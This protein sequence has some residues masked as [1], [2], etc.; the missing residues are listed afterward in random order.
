M[1][2][3]NTDKNDSLVDIY[4]ELDDKRHLNLEQI[5]FMFKIYIEAYLSCRNTFGKD[6]NLT[7]YC[8]SEFKKFYKIIK[9]ENSLFKFMMKNLHK[10]DLEAASRVIDTLDELNEKTV[11]YFV[12]IFDS[13]QTCAEMD[14][15]SRFFFTRK[16]FK[17]LNDTDYYKKMVVGL[18][19]NEEYIR[20]YLNYGEDFWNYVDQYRKS[21]KT[22]PEVASKMAFAVPIFD[23]DN[24]VVS[25]RLFV[26]EVVDLETAIIS[27]NTY[28]KAYNI[29][30]CF[31]RKIDI[32]LEKNVAEEF[33]NSIDYIKLSK[34]RI[35]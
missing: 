31:G 17:D 6:D 16:K 11:L 19:F 35:V 7:F 33:I 14:D 30:K 24:I 10:F 26:P 34:K 21:I 15:S 13:L 4:Y 8:S 3:I 12:D 29:Y 32:N 23:S 18:T 9:Q 22:T 1:E 27:L 20:K 2:Y 25:L 5:Y 28:A